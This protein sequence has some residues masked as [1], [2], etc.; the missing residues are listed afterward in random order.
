MQGKKEGKVVQESG[1]RVRSLCGVR[2]HVGRLGSLT[3][4]RRKEYN[5]CRNLIVADAGE[6][7]I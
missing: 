6:P 1:I 5:P 7:N 4:E 3:N 2:R